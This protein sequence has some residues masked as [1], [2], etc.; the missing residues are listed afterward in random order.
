MKKY[1]PYIYIMYLIACIALTVYSMGQEQAVLRG[2]RYGLG[3]DAVIRLTPASEVI[4][5]FCL[6]GD[7]F[8]GVNVMF[9][10]E[11]KFED[12]RMHA[13]LRDADTQE[14]LADDIVEMKY[15]LIRNTDGGS[16][17]YFALPVDDAADRDVRLVL[18][19]EGEKPRVYP[20]LV[21]SKESVAD[22]I[23]TY[24]GKKQEEELFFTTRY[25]TGV[26]RNV[27]K[28]V[29]TGILWILA[30]TLVFAFTFVWTSGA[31]GKKGGRKTTVQP[32]LSVVGKRFAD[33]TADAGQSAE[34]KSTEKTAVG[35]GKRRKF[36]GLFFWLCFVGVLFVYVYQYGV[37]GAIRK[38]DAY[39]LKEMYLAL[40]LMLLVFAVALYYFCFFR[41]FSP[42][43]IF[44]ALAVIMGICVGSVIALY[45][46]PDEPSH[47]DSAYCL[48]NEILGVPESTRPGHI[49]K[50]ADD[51]DPYAERVRELGLANYESLHD[52]LFEK[53]EDETLVECSALNN[54]SNAGR[55][56]YLPQALGLSV[57]RLLKLGTVPMLLLGRLFSLIVYAILVY[58]AIRK[59][60]FAKLSLALIALLPISL[61]Q[62]ASFSYDAMINAVAFLFVSYCL[63]VSYTEQ[64]IRAG[65]M[66]VILVT[67]CMLAS[68]KGGTYLP[69][70]F[71]P[72]LALLSRKNLTRR[73]KLCTVALVTLCL[74]FF[75]NDRLAATI[76]R[77]STEQGTVTG[78]AKGA[79]IYTFG[80]ILRQ[81]QRLIGMLVNTF[82]E[83]GDAYV[84]NM[85]GGNLA[86]RD[87]NINWFIVFGFL[88]ILLISCIRTSKEYRVS[89]AQKAYIGLLCLGTFGLLELSMLLAWTPLKL[90]YITG[91]QGR[92]FLPFLPLVLVML[93]NSFFQIRR[94]VDRVLMFALGTLDLLTVLQVVQRA[95][96][97]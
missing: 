60:P 55:I 65:E 37:E 6:T 89:G 88:L 67:G 36:I 91:V 21:V 90:N 11:K 26:T 28:A 87:I 16:T 82:Y 81:P 62:A 79:E 24:N 57:G 10:S 68:V 15:E 96:E 5:D 20:D 29:A 75:F 64:E 83:Q 43:R 46:V 70:C 18:S 69:L 54:F 33:S 76:A 12:E 73:Q 53:V 47:I 31:G 72:L 95:L 32:G 1:T 44:P 78:G 71:L 22:S 97:R 2:E 58:L 19:L 77:L 86:W 27:G 59:M 49:Y 40:C 63:Y 52:G 30:G 41:K 66:A 38:E 34:V 51:F 23:L 4:V 39:F 80:Y 93:R 94:N 85:L 8:D 13:V 42:S 84:R 9:Q 35:I 17:V 45:T 7:H 74:L 61:Q 3:R 25:T 92:Y 14:V 56:Y 50:R 48:S